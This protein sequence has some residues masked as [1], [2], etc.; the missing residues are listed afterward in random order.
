MLPSSVFHWMLI[1][2]PIGVATYINAFVSQYE[3][4]RRPE[5]VAIAVWQGVYFSIIAGTLLL[6]GIPLAPMI[7]DWFDH[8]PAVQVLEVQYF[9]TL[10]WGSIPLLVGTTLS[11]FFSGR[12]KTQI[13]MWVSVRRYAGQRRLRLSVN[14]RALRFPRWGIAGAGAATSLAYLASC[15]MYIGLMAWTRYGR[16]YPLWESWRLNPAVFTA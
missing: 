3:G 5:G 6:L 8:D 16:G 13:V 4:A 1:S 14:L 10:C 9:Q 11:C 12:Q 7:F 2:F 15:L